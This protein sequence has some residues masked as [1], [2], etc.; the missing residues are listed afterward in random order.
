MRT[1][2]TV[3]A[4]VQNKHSAPGIC[5]L[6]G[7]SLLKLYRATGKR[8]YL[9]LVRDI[10]HALPQYLSR[11]DR[12]IAACDGRPMPPGWM[13]ERVEMSDWL[14]PVGEI[15]HGSCWCEVS[16]MLAMAELPGLHVRT[17][18]GEVCVLDHVDTSVL[19]DS[20]DRLT[21]RLSNPTPFPARVRVLAENA[22]QAAAPLGQNAVLDWPVVEVAPFGT[23]RLDF[24]RRST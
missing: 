14:E 18:T 6:S 9:E 23:A 11:A 2:G 7:D 12:P 3:Y 8:R 20:P 19:V 13:N 22:A 17:D 16:L 10:A 4:N 1:T 21:L 15:F 24:D 5:T